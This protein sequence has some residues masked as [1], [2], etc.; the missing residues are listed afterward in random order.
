M[1]LKG[2]AMVWSERKFYSQSIEYLRLNWNVMY[3]FIRDRTKT[4]VLLD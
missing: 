3:D 4:I 1:G 2:I